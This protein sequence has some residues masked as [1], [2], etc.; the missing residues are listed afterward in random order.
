MQFYSGV[1]TAQSA[2]K[3][4]GRINKQY[5]HFAPGKGADSA[6]YPRI[7]L[8]ETTVQRTNANYFGRYVEQAI[9]AIPAE[10]LEEAAEKGYPT[11]LVIGPKQYRT[12]VVTHLQECGYAVDTRR[13]TADKL[14]REVGLEVLKEDSTS[15]VGWRVILEFEKDKAFVAN[16]VRTAAENRSRLVDAL[17]AGFRDAITQ[18]VGAFEPTAAT[19]H[20]AT[21]AHEVGAPGVKVTSFEGAKGLSAQH[22]FILGL[23]DG[24]LPRDSRAIDDIEICRFIVGLTR[25]RKK[26][27]LL[28]TRR[29]ADAYKR[30]SPFLSWINDGRYEKV[31]VN[32]AYW[33]QR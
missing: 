22:V 1:D 17:P 32:A 28:H 14:E 5:R 29:F 26:C 16:V 8:V 21:V 7:A 11:A 13:D 33:R 25:T 24:D 12:P 27:Y 30:P 10:E 6:H 19:E 15:N 31:Q 2:G 9:R 18:E 20:Q 23:H 4:G 3:L